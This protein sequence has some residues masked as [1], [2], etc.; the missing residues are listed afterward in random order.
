VGTLWRNRSFVLLF[1]AQLISL[2]GSGATTVGLALFAYAIAGPLEA[3]VVLGNALMLRILAFLLLSQPAGVLA[4][5]VNRKAILVASDVA[6]AMLLSLLP[7][8]STIAHVY[9][10]VFA[11]N[12]VTAFFTPTFEA[13]LPS[14]VGETQLVKA[15]ALSRL[16]VDVEAI[17][18][19]VVA[20]LIVALVGARWVFTFD[21]ATYVASAALILFATVPR[22]ATPSAAPPDARAIGFFAQITF[23]ARAILREPSLRQAVILSFAE[24]IA[25]ACAIVGTVAYVRRSL[26]G[27]ESFV[28]LAMAAVGVGSSG[29]AL[30]LGRSAGRY[31]R[32]AA[33]RDS[34]H[35]RRHA[36]SRRALLGG[37]ALLSVALAPGVLALPFGALLVMW[38]LNGAGQA[39][40]AIPSAAL[41][42]DHS[43][44][45]ERGRVY[46]AHFAL[47]HAFWLVAYPAVGYSVARWGAPLAFSVAA[48]ACVSVTIVA[49]LS[50]PT[51]ARHT[52]D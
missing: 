32:A 29:M 30:F 11:I 20:A 17:A 42:A 3:T 34:R 44:E 25:G 15:L 33:D 40:V 51:A 4:D 9:A 46:A 39:L 16:A 21:A 19:P 41:L 1:G 49:A 37:G 43:A 26:G 2:L 27:S 13:V 12:A 10:L 48:L 28:A 18:A 14:V 31:E 6:R 24:A 52:H 7:F 38:L 5:R 45:T 36:W 22:I 23:G 8:V 50:R 35:G 47:T